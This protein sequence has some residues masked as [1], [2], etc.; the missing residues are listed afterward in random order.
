M[1][2]TI[3]KSA[4]N[5]NFLKRWPQN[6]KIVFFAAPNT[7]SNELIQRF[8]IDLGLPVVSLN[9]VINN[10]IEGAG[11]EEFSHPFFQ[12]VRDIYAAGDLDALS[13][14][15]IAT[16]LLRI[17][18]DAREG[19]ILTDFP[20]SRAEAE[21]LEE[22]RGGMNSFVHLS[23]PDEVSISIEENKHQCQ[24]CNRLY[25]TET[26]VSEEHNI[27][28]EPFMPED[29]HCYDCGSSNIIRTGDAKA[30]E[31]TLVDYNSK[32][33]EVLPF[34][35]HHGLLVDFEVRAGYEDYSRLRDQIQ[36][37]IKH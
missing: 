11:S 37:N 17:T 34:Y 12:R 1:L 30:L 24:D 20:N 33:E 21:Q 13:K 26:I 28:I 35:N 27:R 9:N 4:N 15:R 23:M 14:E 3:F 18:P 16:K 19:F 25:Y 10:V 31:Q 36:F 29:G 22:Y 7:Y 6:P 5:T 32:K 8:A 2:K